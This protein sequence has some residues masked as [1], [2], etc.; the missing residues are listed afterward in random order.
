M[1]LVKWMKDGMVIPPKQIASY[2]ERWTIPIFID[3]ENS[4]GNK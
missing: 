4:R 2:Y 1:L 3:Y